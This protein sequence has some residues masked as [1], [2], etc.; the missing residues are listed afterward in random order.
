MADWLPG[1][2]GI[3]LAA[4]FLGPDDG[5]PVLLLHGSGQRRHSWRE[6]PRRIAASGRRSINVDLRGHGDSDRAPDGRYGWPQLSDDVA[7]LLA[8]IGPAVVV[9]ASAGAK[10]A[11]MAASQGES[12]ARTAA[13]VMVDAVPRT[14]EGGSPFGPAL[15]NPPPE[16]YESPAA[17]AEAVA[18]NR[19]QPVTAEAARRIERSLRQDAHGRWHWHWDTRFFDSSQS[20]AASQSYEMLEV[21]AARVTAPTLLVRGEKSP[22]VSPEGF[23]KLHALIPHAEA[24]VIAGAGHQVASDANAALCDALIDFFDRN[25]L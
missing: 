14:T 19:N 1:A 23:A 10:A 18:A 16:G 9:G 3:R 11:M 2:D 6:V 5:A 7:A 25:R 13:L 12:A 17:A 21:A 15:K 24:V 20:L 22:M 8:A 4:D